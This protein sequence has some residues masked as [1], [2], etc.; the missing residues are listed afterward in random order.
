MVRLIALLVGLAIL[1]GVWTILTYVVWMFFAVFGAIGR[2]SLA[3]MIIVA[4]GVIS[5]AY[6]AMQLFGIGFG[7]K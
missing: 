1:A 4:L 2:K 5:Y 7:K 6:V 3:S